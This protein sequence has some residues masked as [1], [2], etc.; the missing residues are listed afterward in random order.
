[1]NQEKFNSILDYLMWKRDMTSELLQSN[2]SSFPQYEEIL[3]YF[4]NEINTVQFL[5]S[6]LM[7]KKAIQ[8]NPYI[9][10]WLKSSILHNYQNRGVM[11]EDL[12]SFMIYLYGEDVLKEGGLNDL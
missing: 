2:L 11:Y 3:G 6:N 12:N 1:M 10:P 9:Y 4:N 8:D 7:D 5:I